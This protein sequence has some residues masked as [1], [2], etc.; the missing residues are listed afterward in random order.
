MSCSS[1]SIN[2]L[3]IPVNKTNYRRTKA[4]IEH[5][6]DLIVEFVKEQEQQT[7]RQIFY[8]LVVHNIVPKSDSSYN[9]VDRFVNDL[10]YEGRIPFD[11]ILDS[12][13]LYGTRQWSSFQDMVDNARQKYRSNWNEEFDPYIEL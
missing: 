13:G 7:A 5:E 12:T 1:S 3:E 2:I 6:K 11:S 4:E 8:Y 9:M 10:R